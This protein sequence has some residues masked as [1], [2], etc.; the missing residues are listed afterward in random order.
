[1]KTQASAEERQNYL[2]RYPWIKEYDLADLFIT[3][4]HRVAL[5]EHQDHTHIR[6]TR[7]D[8]DKIRDW[9][10]LQLV[11]NEVVGEEVA[12]MQV[13]PPQNNV[14]DGSNTYHLFVPKQGRLPDL[15]DLYKY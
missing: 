6:I 14:R 15:N 9:W 12:A 11:K 5:V 4:K 13:F 7:L 8:G 10:E 2:A 3:D 1:M